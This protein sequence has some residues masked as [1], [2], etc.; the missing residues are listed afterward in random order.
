MTEKLIGMKEF[1]EV[2]TVY[3]TFCTNLRHRTLLLHSNN[4]LYIYTHTFIYIYS[5]Y[6]YIYICIYVY[7]YI[8]VTWIP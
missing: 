2:C 8:Y 3:V 1:V 5:I 4:L 7:I 6:I